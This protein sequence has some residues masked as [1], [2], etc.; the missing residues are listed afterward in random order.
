[1]VAALAV[2]CAFVNSGIGA[3]MNPVASPRR[4][5]V[6]G[7]AP[8]LTIAA[9]LAVSVYSVSQ[10]KRQTANANAGKEEQEIKQLI[11]MYAKAADEADPVLAS[12]I[13]CDSSDDSLINPVGRWQGVEQIMGFYRHEMGEMYSARD[14]EIS[15]VAVRVN[16][17]TAW[18]EFNWNFSAKRRKDGSAV[19]FHG[20]E[21]QIYQKGRDRWCLV[22]VHYSALPPEKKAGTK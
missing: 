10:D 5:S 16:S 14:L 3:R 18:A 19:S 8:L 13:W 6:A 1:M 7:F 21:T 2:V 15:Q 12:R 11:S 20:M 22:H 9:L 4:P 17:D